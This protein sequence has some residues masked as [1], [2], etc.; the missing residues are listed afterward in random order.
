MP[1]TRFCQGPR[2]KPQV[3]GVPRRRVPKRCE[4]PAS[5]AP[6]R[7]TSGE[8]QGIEIV[9]VLNTHVE[10]ASTVEAGRRFPSGFLWGSATSSYQIE[11]AATLDGRGESIWD[12]F[13]ARPGAITDGSDGAVACDHYH[14]FGEDIELMKRLNLNAYRFSIAWPRVLPAGTRA[15]QPTRSRL[16]RP[17]GRRAARRR[18]SSR[19]R[20][21]TTGTFRRSWRTRVGGRCGRR[22]KRL[23][24]TPASP[25]PVSATASAIG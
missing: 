25:P 10:N 4:P 18:G 1:E 7:R 14:R 20:P 2:M 23:P 22:P 13:C 12:R 15:G 19:C 5:I 24:T 21:C 9:S 11:G 17:A 3:T 16:L 6:R 8:N